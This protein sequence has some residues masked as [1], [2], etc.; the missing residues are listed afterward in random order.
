MRIRRFKEQD[1]PR[2]VEICNLSYP[3]WPEDEENARYR[4]DKLRKEMYL[5]EFVTEEASEIV[6]YA[7]ISSRDLSC[8]EPGVFELEVI[9]HPE[10]RGRGHGRA[11]M[12]L[13]EHHTAYLNWRRLLTGCMDDGGYARDW[14]QRRGFVHQETE[15]CSKLDLKN[16]RPPADHDSALAK[17]D[18]QGCRLA[19]YGELS[20]PD[21]ERKLWELYE[22]ISYD[23]PGTVEYKK[24]DLEEWRRKM[25]APAHRVEA[26]MLALEGDEFVGL[27]VL[28]FPAGLKRNAVVVNTGTRAPYRHRGVATALKYA[29]MDRAKATGVP[30]IVTGN[31]Q[32]NE[33]IL[34]INRKLG[35]KPMKPW[36]C[37][38]KRKEESDD[39]A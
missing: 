17:I 34:K 2:L 23:M 7:Q 24:A 10:H 8:A 12:D 5:Q 3:D 30:A 18:E 28:V 16:Y 13:I 29:S 26:I 32:H 20:D 21:K 9:V 6:G 25:G 36:L 19:T 15:L 4:R 11:L 14:L 1:L 27:T 38:T 35:F 37:Y 33:A 31:E 39:T 22:E